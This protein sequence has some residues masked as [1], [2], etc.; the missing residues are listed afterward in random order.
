MGVEMTLFKRG[1]FTS[2]SGIELPYK[3]ECDALT[4]DDIECVAEYIASK[5]DCRFMVQDIAQGSCRLATALEKHERCDAPF[6]I[7]LVDEVLLT[8]SSMKMAKDAQPPQ[9]HKDDIIG[10]VIFARGELPSWIHA[11]FTMEI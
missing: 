2:H 4:D 10:W 3:I 9:V 7:L 5:M 6:V 11:V 1:N 8:P